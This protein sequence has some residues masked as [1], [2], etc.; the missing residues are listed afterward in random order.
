MG[1][2]KPGSDWKCKCGGTM[3]SIMSAEPDIDKERLSITEL[4]CFN[5]GLRYD[6]V[7]K[8]ESM[9]CQGCFKNIDKCE[10][11]GQKK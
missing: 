11:K 9:T 6:V 1:N 3:S 5:C 2:C 8:M 7:Y 10:C 4:E